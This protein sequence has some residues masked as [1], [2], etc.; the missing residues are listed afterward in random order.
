[1][2]FLQAPRASHTWYSR[3]MLED[4]RRCS[5]RQAWRRRPL[6]VHTSPSSS[7]N[8]SPPKQTSTRQDIE[9]MNF[10]SFALHVSLAPFSLSGSQLLM[11]GLLAATTAVL[12]LKSNSAGGTP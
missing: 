2:R 4:G 5:D 7:A 10:F 8:A 1:M 11:S 3:R 12:V 6:C 9:G